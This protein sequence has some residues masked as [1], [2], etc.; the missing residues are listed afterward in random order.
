MEQLD[1]RNHPQ[2]AS[3]MPRYVAVLTENSSVVEQPHLLDGVTMLEHPGALLPEPQ[4]ALYSATLPAQQKGDPVTLRLIPY[5]AWCNRA[6]TSMQVWIPYQ[7][8]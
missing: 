1:Q 3:L 7:T 5:Y 2:D 6:S 4:P 8:A